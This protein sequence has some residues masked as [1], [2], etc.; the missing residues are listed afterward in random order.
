MADISS[1]TGGGVQDVH[2]VNSVDSDGNVR[3]AVERADEVVE[4]LDRALLHLTSLSGET[5]EAGEAS[6]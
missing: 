3:V 4:Q 2:L 5:I 1:T 6:E